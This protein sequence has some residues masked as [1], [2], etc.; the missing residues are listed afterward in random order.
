MPLKELNLTVDAAHYSGS[1][2]GWTLRVQDPVSRCTLVEITVEPE[3][4]YQ[5]LASR[6][7]VPVTGRVFEV[8]DH[9]GK[10]R[11]TKWVKLSDPRL[12]RTP[13]DDRQKVID[14][15]IEESRAE[16]EVDGWVLCKPSTMSLSQNQWDSRE[17]TLSVT[18]Q[19]FIDAHWDE[20]ADQ[21][22]ASQGEEDDDR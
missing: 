14:R 17:G 2:S 19:R 12:I 21:A 5:I 8:F 1:S 6:G 10:E 13:W 22:V 16:H 9:L 18:A 3:Q 4:F 11:E 20:L 15:V 7:A